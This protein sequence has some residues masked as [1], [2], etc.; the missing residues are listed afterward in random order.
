ME[1]HS[2]RKH[3]PNVRPSIPCE[4]CGKLFRIKA[5]L[6]NHLSR[7]HKARLERKHRCYDCDLTFRTEQALMSH[8]VLHDLSRPL[9]CSRCTLRYKNKDSL[10][11]HEKTHDTAQFKCSAP[12]CSVAFKRRDNLKR[13]IKSKHGGKAGIVIQQTRPIANIE[14]QPPPQQHSVILQTHPQDLNHDLQ[15]HHEVISL[16]F[17]QGQERPEIITIGGEMVH[18]VVHQE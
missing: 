5:D 15:E 2:Q 7:T 14:P 9:Q 4:E 16:N 1:L 13:H 6:R 18:M 12:G 10:V 17:Q 8:M 3:N 11:A